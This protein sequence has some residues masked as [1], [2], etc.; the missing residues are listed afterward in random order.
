MKHDSKSI[1]D[2]KLERY[3][4]GELSFFQMKGVKERLKVDEKAKKRLAVLRE[5]NEEILTFYPADAMAEQIRERWKREVSHVNRPLRIVTRKRFRNK[6][7]RNLTLV[8]STA[9]LLLVILFPIRSIVFQ[10]RI[11]KIGEGTRVKGLEPHLIVYRKRGD[12][13]ERLKSGDTVHEHDILQ[14]SYRAGEKKYGVIFSIDGRGVVTLHYPYR[15]A[16]ESTQSPELEQDREVTLAFSYELDDA[17]DFERF[18]FVSSSKSFTIDVVREAVQ[19]LA[20]SLES[21]RKGALA[22]PSGFDQF[23]FVLEKEVH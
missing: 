1:P 12:E 4:L 15:D 22:L 23:S 8:V 10:D 17:P 6:R 9:A 14:L 3:L 2:W 7:F 19:R 5:S 18:F 21:A 20:S 16:G 13:A 11:G